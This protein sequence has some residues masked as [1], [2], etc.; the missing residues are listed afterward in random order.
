MSRPLRLL[1]VEDSKDDADLLVR[2]VR[3]AGYV[4]VYEIVDTAP[5]M[6]DALKHD[7]WDLIIS[8]CALPRFAAPAALALAKELRPDLPFIVVSGSIDIN[9]AVSLIKAGAHDYIQKS[10]MGRL[11]PAIKRALHER[12]LR[13]TEHHHERPW[14][15]Q[16]LQ[17]SETR[18][19]RLFEAAQDGRLILNAETAQ[20]VD[21][22]PFVADMLGYS[23]D[24]CIGKKLWEIGAFKDIEACKSGFLELQAKGYIRYEDLPL[25]TSDGRSIDVEF[26]SNVYLADSE[27]LVQCTIR[28]ITARVRAAANLRTL[29]AELRQH[30]QVHANQ[31]EV[32]NQEL[33]TFNYA[34]S[35]DLCAPLRRI[36][37]FTEALE[38]DYPDK[39][40]AEGRALIQSICAAAEHMDTLIDG[41][42]R[43][44]RLSRGEIRPQATNLS[45]MVHTIGAELH[46]ADPT[47]QVELVVA[48]DIMA[49]GDRALLRIVLENL[50]SNAWKFTSHRATARIEFGA[51]QQS[52]GLLAYFVA[53][54]GAGFDMK[55]ADTLFGPFQRFHNP[56]EFPGTGIGLASVQRIVHRHRGRIWAQSTVGQGT[57]F[58]FTLD[59]ASESDQGMSLSV[60]A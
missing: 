16:T 29:N 41:L 8:D 40:D 52:D 51:K 11:V 55:Y 32:L 50:L 15:E 34:V 43:L 36:Q 60:V 31:L 57:T 10:Q 9:L 58:Y 37:G 20:I 21:A 18:Y 38:K 7:D 12:V 49:N 30:V 27:K 44:S 3:S 22:N 4:P 39:L 23:R 25:A 2:A 33:E 46:D 54:N 17:A 56:N 6:R 26:I 53:D 45:T 28:D 13:Q 14:M 42:L 19:R 48:E 35:H 24:H 59:A 47:R 5:A 1:I